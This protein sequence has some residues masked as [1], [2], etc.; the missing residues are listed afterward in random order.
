MIANA[1]PAVGYIRMSTDKQEDSPARQRRDIEELAQRQ[2]FRIVG[3]YE[4]HGLTG[5]E[6]L[7]RPEFQRLLKN[8]QSGKFEAILLSEQSRMSREDI[9]DAM[10]HWKILRDA[11]VRVVTCQ[12]GE[13]DFTNLGGVI[14]AIVDQYGAREESVKLAQRVASGQRLKAMNGQ[15]IGGFVF[16]YDREIYDDKGRAVKRVHFQER[17]RRPATWSSRLV[18]S[19]DRKAVDGVRWAFKACAEGRSLPAIATELNRRGLK[20]T[21]GNAFTVSSVKGLLENPTY[22]GVLRVGTWSRSKF[23]SVAENGLIEIDDA[24]PSIIDRDLYDAAQVNLANRNHPRSVFARYL[25]S[26]IVTCHHCG[27]NLHGVRRLQPSRNEKDAYYDC[28]KSKRNGCPHPSVRCEKLEAFVLAAIQDNLLADKMEQRVRDAITKAKRQAAKGASREHRKLQ[29]LR[30]KIERGT[31]NLALADKNEFKAISA[32]LARWQAEETEL[33]IRIE[34]PCDDL[35]PL[36]EALKILKRLPEIRQN[37]KRADHGLLNDAIAKTI[38]SLTIGVRDAHVGEISYREFFGEL[39]FHEAFGVQPLTI[40]DAAI[41]HRHLWM[42]LA[43][44]VRHANRP[45]HLRDFYELIGTT[46]P[47]HAAYHVRRAERTGLIK[48]VGHQG[49]WIKN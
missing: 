39:A 25:L 5:T 48:K 9:F 46:D 40:P 7:N 49:G 43:E 16:G 30:R 28:D 47:S 27:R 12:R 34:R 11:G 44:M 42:E 6:S 37:I 29:D 18:I 8:A 22:A 38:A 10:M 14:T 32:L 20:T 21:Y 26:G 31:E 17:F 13:L 33:A 4:D 1:K 19:N 3:W 24:H 36:P 41:G 45:L 2:N 23:C 15:R 35:E